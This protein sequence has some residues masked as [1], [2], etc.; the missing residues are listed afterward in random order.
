MKRLS[1]FCVVL[2]LCALENL[3]AQDA[4]TEERLNK[5]AGLVKDLQEDKDNQ[6][7][8]M[9]ALARELQSVREQAAR[10]TGNYAS[11][12]AVSKLAEAIKEIDEKRE[13]DKKLILKEIEKLGKLM[14]SS[15]AGART[16][17]KAPPPKS[18]PVKPSGG[19][20]TGFEHTV[21]PGDTLS[22]IEQAYREQGYKVSVKQILEANPGLV[23]ERM[24][25]GQK[26]W[27]PAPPK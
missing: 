24:K 10:P 9:E 20:E 25:V 4:A 16:P 13:A 1:I 15:S 6:R 18:E 27:I 23:P 2:S 22:G 26:I 7:R 3:R 21:Q 11:Q 8:Q 5:L 19:G 12:E 14:A 17:P